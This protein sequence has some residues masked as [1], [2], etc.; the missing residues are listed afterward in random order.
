M[1]RR[2]GG[3]RKALWV[4]VE[5]ETSH[6]SP[7]AYGLLRVS[8]SS[9]GTDFVGVDEDSLRGSTQGARLVPDPGALSPP[10]GSAT[11]AAVLE[12]GESSPASP[13]LVPQNPPSIPPKQWGRGPTE[14]SYCPSTLS[15][16]G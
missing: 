7:S 4:P 9:G 11:T 15:D 12:L 13:A 16:K 5:L 8:G 6:L 10:E 14:T 1:R 2:R 3:D